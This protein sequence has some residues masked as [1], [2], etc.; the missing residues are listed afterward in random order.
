MV[1]KEGRGK[2]AYAVTQWFYQLYSLYYQDFPENLI[3][4]LDP[5]QDHG[6]QNCV[7]ISR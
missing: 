5:F 7:K 2:T 1:P 3:W 4:Y 6:G